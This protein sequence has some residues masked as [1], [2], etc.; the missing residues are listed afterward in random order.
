MSY[1]KGGLLSLNL[2]I[3]DCYPKA[4]YKPDNSSRILS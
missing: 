4:Q 1:F 3:N 2:S